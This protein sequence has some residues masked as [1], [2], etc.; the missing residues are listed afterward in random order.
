MKEFTE[1]GGHRVEIWRRPRQRSLRLRV[2]PDGVLRVTCAV[3]VPKAAVFAFIHESGEFIQ[4]SLLK[5]QAQREQHPPRQYETGEIFLIDGERLPLVMVWSWNK[6]IRVQVTG[7]AL[8]MVAPLTS[9]RE[10][11]KTALKNFLRKRAGEELRERAVELSRLVGKAPREISIRGQTTRWGS[12]T[13]KGVINLNWKLLSAPADVVDYV[14][15]HELAHLTFLDHSPRFW[16]LVERHFPE[17]QKAKRW[18]KVHEPEIA[19]Q[20]E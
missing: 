17:Y 11:R 15:V 13:S 9:T 1:F 4:K 2:L 6:R 5:I 14:I 3:R 10:E 18:L 8:E 20:F 16:S 12:C 7:H 19:A